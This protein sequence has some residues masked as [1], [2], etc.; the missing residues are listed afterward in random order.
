MAGTDSPVLPDDRYAGYVDEVITLAEKLFPVSRT[1]RSRAIGGWSMG[2]DGAMYTACRRSGDF[3]AAALIIGI[4]DLPGCEG[5]QAELRSAAALRH[6]SGS[7]EKL[8]RAAAMCAWRQCS[9][10]PMPTRP[11]SGR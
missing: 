8:I 1:A 3:A 2:G 11:P 5:N 6:R 4:L 9:S 10:L 7:V